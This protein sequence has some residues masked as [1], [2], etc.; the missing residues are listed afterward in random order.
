MIAMEDIYLEEVIQYPKVKQLGNNHLAIH[1][2]Q[3][4]KRFYK[5]HKNKSYYHNQLI[6]EL[7][8]RQENI[9]L[10]RFPLGRILD[11]NNKCTGSNQLDLKKYKLF[12]EAYTNRNLQYKL[13]LLENLLR[14]LEEL[15][16]NGIYHLDLNSQ[17]I[18]YKKENVQIIDWDDVYTCINDGLDSQLEAIEL[19]LYEE[20][21]LETILG[22]SNYPVSELRNIF[23]KMNNFLQEKYENNMYQYTFKTSFNILEFLDKNEKKLIL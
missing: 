4:D 16:Q 6:I 18:L 7:C 21:L 3:K 10:T 11:Q 5:V 15:H 13:T 14:N 1:I 20:I 19:K 2:N 12:S 8:K 17:N 9:K 23:F 22:I